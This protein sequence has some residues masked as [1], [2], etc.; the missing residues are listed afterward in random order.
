M[1]PQIVQTITPEGG[2]DAPADLLGVQ[3]TNLIPILLLGLKQLI[4][5]IGGAQS[6]A[7]NGPRPDRPRLR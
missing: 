4:P 3:Y 2:A 1:L 5:L 7:N 6:R